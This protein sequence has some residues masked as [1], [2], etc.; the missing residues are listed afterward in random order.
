MGWIEKIAESI[1]AALKT[2]RP[3]ITPIPP[4]LLLCEIMDRP[5]LSAT[6]LTSSIIARLPEIGIPTGVNPDGSANKICQYTR[7]VAEELINELHNNGVVDCVIQPGTINV[8]GTGI[9]AGIPAVQVTAVNTMLSSVKG[10][11]R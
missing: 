9:A 11:F 10:I 3:P 5:G 7:I 8:S 4:V 1:N 6:S 2:L